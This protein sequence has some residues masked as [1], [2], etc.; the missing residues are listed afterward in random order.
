MDYPV[1]FSVQHPDHFN[2]WTVL[3]R[4]ILAIPIFLLAYGWEWS[5]GEHLT[6]YVPGPL[7]ALIG[8]MVLYAWFTILFTGRFPITMRTASIF[9]FRWIINIGAY[10]ILLAADYPPFGEGE[11]PV[12][13]AIT[14]A[15]HYN[16]LSVFFRTILVIPH[17]VVLF[18]LFIALYVVT[19]IAW[20]AILFTRRYPAGMFNFSVGVI[21][22]STRVSAYLYLFVDE[23]PPFSLSEGTGATGLQPQTA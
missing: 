6:Y 8:L 18:F 7:T 23:Y 2:R 10:V 15:D 11:Y 4:P 17:I 14:P 1:E 5:V 16:R 21:R 3:F 9:V 13:L 22:W 19:V 12:N 20:F